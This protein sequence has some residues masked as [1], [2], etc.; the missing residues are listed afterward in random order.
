MTQRVLIGIAGCFL[1][2]STP[3]AAQSWP[4]TIS[5]LNNIREFSTSIE[6]QQRIRA[7]QWA[8]R[9]NIPLL[10]PQADGSSLKLVGI[11]GIRPVYLTP[12]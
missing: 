6:E 11:D 5:E 7:E 1:M 8:A 9:R 10:L 2:F 3:S 12:P 4:E